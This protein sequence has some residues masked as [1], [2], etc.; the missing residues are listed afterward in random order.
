MGVFHLQLDGQ[1]VAVRP[2]V[3]HHHGAAY[4]LDRVFGTRSLSFAIALSALSIPDQPEDRP[5]N[6]FAPAWWID[7]KKVDRLTTNGAVVFP[8][9][10]TDPMQNWHTSI[11][12]E[13]GGL[14][15]AHR[16]LLGYARQA[17]TFTV[18]ETAGEYVAT[19]GWATFTQRYVSAGRDMGRGE[20]V[21]LGFM[22]DG[23]RVGYPWDR[24]T[25]A[26]AVRH[27]T[28]HKPI[29]WNDQ[30]WG[31]LSFPGLLRQQE[32]RW[33]TA[34]IGAVHLMLGPPYA[35]LASCAFPPLVLRPGQTL[36]VRYVAT[37]HEHLDENDEL[38][39]D[40]W[41]ST[42]AADWDAVPATL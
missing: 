37:I 41:P 26:R 21:N 10:I 5:D 24:R 14:Y 8:E 39:G 9:Q 40:D 22:P 35:P 17:V 31:D 15:Q 7:W 2:N 12:D 16:Y 13:G 38:T 32:S 27:K 4:A 36:S 11:A 34:P 28:T 1:P 25:Y 33:D 42:E 18:A 19:S 3:L 30:T 29:P 6:S 23:K 20:L